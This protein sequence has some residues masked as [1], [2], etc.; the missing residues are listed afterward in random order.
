MELNQLSD[1]AD[2]DLFPSNTGDPPYNY[3]SPCLESMKERM[4]FLVESEQDGWNVDYF[5]E[6]PEC[7]PD[8]T[9]GRV[10]RRSGS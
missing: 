8:G 2:L 4:E 6:I 5:S 3:T 10:V 1:E 7:L 9:F